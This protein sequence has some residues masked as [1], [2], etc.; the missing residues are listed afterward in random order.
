MKKLPKEARGA[1]T[2]RGVSD[3]LTTGGTG[4]AEGL[5]A[6]A[7]LFLVLAAAELIAIELEDGER[8]RVEVVVEEEG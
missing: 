3:M 7:E 8:K 2:S 6:G 1:G 4:D 5:P